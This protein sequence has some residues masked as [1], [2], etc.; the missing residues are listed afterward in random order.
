MERLLNFVY[1]YRA[2]FTFL[3]LE[4]FCAWLII[5]NNQ[6]QST[7]Y[8]NTSNRIAAGIIGFSQDVREYFS[9]RNINSELAKENADLRTQ[10]EQR[11]QS[12]NALQDSLKDSTATSRYTYVSAKVINNSTRY[13]KNF[14]TINKGE[15]D[16][17]Q[18]G[19]AA[20][21]PIGAVGKVKSVSD[22]FAV[23]IS[24]LNIDDQMSCVINRTGHFG[25][26]QWDGTDPRFVNL[27]YIPRHVKP[28]VGDTVSTS[29]FNA[30]FPEGILVGIITEV[31]LKEESPFY[32]LKVELA[33]DFG[34]LAYV[35]VVQ[36]HLKQE[37]DLLEAKTI[38]EPK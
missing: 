37:K 13:Y 30:V 32:D 26:V 28:L 29:G 17:I 5:E 27:K 14:I 15:L 25:T 12:V 16:G 4:L 19:M 33:Q 11:L 21:S 1:E 23:L 20:I 36:S 38:G 31:R 3:L 2:F 8:F 18:P 35:Q 24:V 10:L 6:Y 9:L 22:H 7:R 34:S